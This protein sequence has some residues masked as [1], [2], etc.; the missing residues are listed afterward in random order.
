MDPVVLYTVRN[1]VAEIELNRRDSKNALDASMYMLLAET[2]GK[3]ERD[4]EVRVLLI[5]G[6]EDMFCA[7][8]DLK[9]FADE[10]GPGTKPAL[11]LMDAVQ[12]LKKPLIAAV[13]G[14]AVGIGTTLLYH[15]DVVYAAENARFGMPFVALGVC[16]EF[17][18]SRLAP[19]SAGYRTA[20][21]AIL[22]AE[23]FD[24]DYAVRA[25]I[26]SRIVPALELLGYARARAEKLASMPRAAVLE[27]KKLLKNHSF[28]DMPAVF[29]EELAVF[30]ALLESDDARRSI[31]AFLNRKKS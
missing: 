4:P 30:D 23:Q 6:Q 18:S 17:G 31:A 19:L 22:F 11:A 8:N 12:S 21:E 24:A 1:S 20:A 13:A 9:D 2:L 27:S 5:R 25:G 26:V 28:R 15:C 3:A 29:R 7:G 16:P 14:P 10:T